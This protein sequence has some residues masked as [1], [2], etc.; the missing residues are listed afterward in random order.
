MPAQEISQP[1]PPPDP[2]SLSDDLLQLS[3]QLKTEGYLPPEELNAVQAF[4]RAADYIAAGMSLQLPSFLANPAISY[5][6]FEGQCPRR[7]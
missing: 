2:S 6:I 7:A 3:V 5:D 1:N 4:R